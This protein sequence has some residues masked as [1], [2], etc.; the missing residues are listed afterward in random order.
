MGG[1]EPVRRTCHSRAKGPEPGLGTSA[2]KCSP[3]L[4]PVAAT[5]CKLD[6]E[7]GPRAEIR[8]SGALQTARIVGLGS[9]P[10]APRHNLLVDRLGGVSVPFAGQFPNDHVPVIHR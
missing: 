10:L 3:H 5:D 8:N 7:P 4:A 1:P 6:G 9:L 2:P